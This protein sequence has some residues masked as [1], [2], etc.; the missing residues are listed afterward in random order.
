MKK[1]I[2]LSLAIALIIERCGQEKKSPIEGAWK[3][4]Y[5]EWIVNNQTFTFPDQISGEQI[6]MVTKKHMIFI[7]QTKLPTDT[8]FQP[9]YGWATYTLN[10]NKF[11][12]IVNFHYS[13][14]A[15]GRSLRMLMEVRNDTC[16][17][18]FFTNENWELP[19]KYNTEIYVRLD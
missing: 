16:I 13:K 6:K 17:Q 4:V 11:E 2:F 12:E 19:D 10:G 5:A 14:G 8:V 18:K 9:K 1:V 3:L 7:G 15:I